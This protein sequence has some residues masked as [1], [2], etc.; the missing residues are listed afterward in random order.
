MM[1]LAAAAFL[2]GAFVYACLNRMKKGLTDAGSWF[3]VELLLCIALIHSNCLR[4]CASF[5]AASSCSI[6]VWTAFVFHTLDRAFLGLIRVALC[7][8]GFCVRRVA[9]AGELDAAAAVP[10]A[11]RALARHS[12]VR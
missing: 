3:S 8:P 4:V 6:C 12:R 5:A 7:L 9:R 1:A 10:E 2:F 11:R